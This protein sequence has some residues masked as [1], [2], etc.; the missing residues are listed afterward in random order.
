VTSV[1]T[2]SFASPSNAPS[3]RRAIVNGRPMF[4]ITAGGLTGYWVPASAVTIDA[5][6][7]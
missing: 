7:G 4:Q 6:P 1:K 2:V 3:D 5:E